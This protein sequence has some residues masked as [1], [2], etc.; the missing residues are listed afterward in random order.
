[1][2]NCIVAQVPSCVND[3][4]PAILPCVGRSKPPVGLAVWIDLK[5]LF[6]GCPLG[7]LRYPIDLDAESFGRL[8]ASI[9]TGSGHTS[10]SM[11]RIS[12]HWHG[13]RRIPAI[14][15]RFPL[16]NTF[17]RYFGPNTA[18]YRHQASFDPLAQPADLVIQKA[19]PGQYPGDA[20]YLLRLLTAGSSRPAC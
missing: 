18:W 3:R 11:I 17:L 16:Y 12:F 15:L 20:L 13:I 7:A 19:P 10:A 14:S 9:W 1:M 8:S 4:S 5:G 6:T 2:T